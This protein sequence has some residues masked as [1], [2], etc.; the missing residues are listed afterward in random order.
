MPNPECVKST[1]PQFTTDYMIKI[2]QIL[3][4]I[5]RYLL[6]IGQ[7]ITPIYKSTLIYRVFKNDKSK[8]RGV[9]GDAKISGKCQRN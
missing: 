5:E 1:E 9:V 7:S 8:I 6:N 3:N 4:E 2:S